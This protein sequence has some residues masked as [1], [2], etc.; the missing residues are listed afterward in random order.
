MKLLIFG[1][2][3]FYLNRK[4]KIYPEDEIVAFIDNRASELDEFEGKKVYHPDK[5]AIFTG[6]KILLMSADYISMLNQLLELGVD[7]QNIIFWNEYCSKE[8]PLIAGGKIISNRLSLN[9]LIITEPLKLNGGAVAAIN[10]AVALSERGFNITVLTRDAESEIVDNLKEKEIDVYIHSILPILRETDIDWCRQFDVVLINTILLF[11][12][13]VQLNRFLPTLLWIHESSDKYYDFFKRA[14]ATNY[15]YYDLNSLDS[16]RVL[17]VSE[18][19]KDV[20]DAVFPN[21]VDSIVA[22]AI[23]DHVEARV[24]KDN[25]IKIGL[26]GGIKYQKGT[27]EFVQAVNRLFLLGDKEIECFLIGP[28]YDD[29]YY[30]KV[31]DVIDGNPFIKILGNKSRND[32]F[33]YYA[34]LDVIVCSSYEETLS[35]TIVEGMMYGKLC[36]TTDNTGISEYIYDGING[37]ICKS[38]DVDSLYRKLLFVVE[39]IEELE[40]VR[41]KARDTYQKYF[42]ID[43]LGDNLVREI[44]KAIENY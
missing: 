12:C 19:G 38:Q 5:V 39:H 3:K 40:C 31:I 37:Y 18:H 17:A 11:G 10:A 24:K 9:I 7:K 32:L 6:I 27:L 8:K 20:I 30:H 43:K 2:G 26:V 33:Q 22:P 21:A 14:I 13:A 23:E 16:T 35:L 41:Q 42:T 15:R 36:I 34:E 29:E 4:N 28:H 1:T 25:K 44:K